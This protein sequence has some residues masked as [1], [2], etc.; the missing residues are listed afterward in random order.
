MS[1]LPVTAWHEWLDDP[2]LADRSSTDV[3]AAHKIALKGQSMRK[4]QVKP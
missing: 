2:T 1:Q 4:K 3:H